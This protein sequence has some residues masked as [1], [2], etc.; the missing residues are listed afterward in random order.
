MG[1]IR[2]RL[3]SWQWK[4][5]RPWS[6]SKWNPEYWWEGRRRV[7]PSWCFNPQKNAPLLMFLCVFPSRVCQPEP[8]SVWA[9]CIQP[10]EIF[11]CLLTCLS[12]SVFPLLACVLFLMRLRSILIW[13]QT[14]MFANK[15]WHNTSERQDWGAEIS[16]SAGKGGCNSVE[17]EWET[18]LWA[19]AWFQAS[20]WGFTWVV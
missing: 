7:S 12:A 14:D 17:R 16:G 1:T 6:S 13:N 8:S 10:L 19:F 2:I 11:R 15:W 20:R 9:L 3:W 5:T 4:T 18:G